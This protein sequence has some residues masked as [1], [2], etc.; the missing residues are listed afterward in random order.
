MAQTTV[1]KVNGKVR[2]TE[3]DALSDAMEREYMA[4]CAGG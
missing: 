1:A 2:V 3:R 4:A